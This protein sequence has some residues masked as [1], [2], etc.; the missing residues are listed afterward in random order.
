MKGGRAEERPLYFE[1]LE[2]YLNKG[3]AP[4]RGFIRGRRKYM[5]SPMPEVYDLQADFKESKNLAPDTDL[6][7]LR[8][9][10]D[11]IRK[12]LSSPRAGA[13]RPRGRSGRRWSGCGAWATRLRPCSSRK[14][15][16]GRATI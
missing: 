10:L 3:C 2:P 7:S 11:R 13:R 9:E 5:D 1:S 14:R 16:T 12:D 8:K 6:G 4:L 15:L